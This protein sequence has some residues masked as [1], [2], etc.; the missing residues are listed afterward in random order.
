L[1]L[2]SEDYL[3]IPSAQSIGSFTQYIEDTKFDPERNRQLT[4]PPFLQLDLE[5][6]NTSNNSVRYFLT[7]MNFRRELNRT[8]WGQD[9]IYAEIDGGEAW[10]RRKQVKMVIA[11]YEKPLSVIS[12]VDAIEAII[13]KASG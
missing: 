4:A 12:A 7:K 2:Q 11:D 6:Q 9:L 1:R 13:L 3:P 10:G 8:F 5:S